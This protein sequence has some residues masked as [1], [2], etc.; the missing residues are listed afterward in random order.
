MGFLTLIKMNT[1][2][3]VIILSLVMLTCICMKAQENLE[4]LTFTQM[5]RSVDLSSE[6]K[7]ADLIRKFQD[8]EARQKLMNGPLSPKNGKCTIEA[9]RKK[10]VILITIPAESLFAPNSPEL[11]E[12]APKLLSPIKRYMKDPDMFRVLLVM[13]TDNT[14]SEEY[15]ENI[16]AERVDAVTDWFDENGAD[17]SFTFSYAF[18]DESPI[19]PNTSMEN[20]A[21]NRRLE[22]YL[23][24]GEKMLSEAKKGKIDF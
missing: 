18:S 10:E 21:K 3:R 4:D 1:Y 5:I 22:I 19:V 13:H 6:P 8:L 7:A 11:S 9:F 16:T 17:T 2:S 12:T 24:P 23:M 15:R 14:G 20:R